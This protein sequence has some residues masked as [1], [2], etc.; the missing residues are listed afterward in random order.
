VHVFDAATD[1][2]F[3]VSGLLLASDGN[4]YG[5]ASGVGANNEGTLF[6]LTAAGAF[7]V[8]HNFGSVPSDGFNPVNLVQ[9]TNGLLY[10]GTNAGGAM[11]DGFWD[12]VYAGQDGG[13]GTIFSWNG[14]LPAFVKTVPY[15]GAVGATVEILG[16]GFTPTTTVSFN[17]VAATVKVQSGTSLLT[18]VPAG[19]TTGAVSVT[20]SS[21]TLTGNQQFVVVP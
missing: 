1:G 13:C 10:G 4:F 9:H 21:G 8:I 19:A 3:P 18:S 16:Q 17:G 12:C 7:S 11:T 2:A 6:Q 5:T 15:M 20:T 14:G